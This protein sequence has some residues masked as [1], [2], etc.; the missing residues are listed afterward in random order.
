[1]ERNIDLDVLANEIELLAKMHILYG[2]DRTSQFEKQK[3]KIQEI[4]LSHKINV[5][6]EIDPISKNL[7]CRYFS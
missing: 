4:I 5:R 1:M 6:S 7:Y 3:E 2:L